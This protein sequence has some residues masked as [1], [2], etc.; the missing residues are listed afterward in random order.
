[1]QD[2]S[3]IKVVHVWTGV[4][5]SKSSDQNVIHLLLIDTYTPPVS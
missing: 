1:M 4:L 2:E 3:I 5:Y